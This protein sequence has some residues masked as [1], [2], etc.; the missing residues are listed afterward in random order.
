MRIAVCIKPVP[1]LATAYVSKS[2][3]ELVEETKRVPNPADENAAEI[4]LSLRAEGDEVTAFAVAP[5]TAAEALR[6]IL[7]MGADR[8]FLVDDS[9]A[10]DG[11]ALTNA[12]AL[13]AAIRHAGDFD[14]ILCGARSVV[15][16][17]GQV[18][19]RV[20]QALGVPHASRVISATIAG[21]MVAVTRAGSL[22]D[23]RLTLP[24][25]LAVEPGCNRPRI[26][27][28]M[29]AIKAAR[30]PIERLSLEQ[31]GVAPDQVGAAGAAVRPRVMH[32]PEA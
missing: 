16:D 25:L 18:G 2:R 19:P 10:Q 8:A 28:A 12:T 31:L 6:P 27:T 5:Q 15:H 7:A 30:R 29:A 11:D 24:A 23:A 32:L 21:A 3:I 1:D 13:A 22:G 14:L 4:A 9:R 20:A 26:P 17:A